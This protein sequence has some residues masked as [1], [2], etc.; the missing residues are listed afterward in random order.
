MT[1]CPLGTYCPD[2][3]MILPTTCPKK[4]YCPEKNMTT[5]LS[6]PPGY[7]CPREGVIRP[8]KCP[9]DHYC[10]TGSEKPIACSIMKYAEAGSSSCSMAPIFYVILIVVLA[11]MTLLSLIIM[12]YA[13]EK[14]LKNK[15][16]EV[17][18]ERTSL[19]PEPEG[20]QYSG[21]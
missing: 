4:F 20:P 9:I 3:G 2:V 17:V 11:F 13:R 15:T 6:C 10:P 8:E 19:I 16:V 1:K 21:L 5:P 18:Q 14:Y 12:K 7:F